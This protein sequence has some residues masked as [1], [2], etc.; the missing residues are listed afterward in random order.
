MTKQ[1]SKADRGNARKP[2]DGDAVDESIEE[3]VENLGAL[4]GVG[5]K[6]APPTKGPIEGEQYAP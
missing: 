1:K 6:A 5:P 3:D 4:F 2:D